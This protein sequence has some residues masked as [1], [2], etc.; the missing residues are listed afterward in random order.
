MEVRDAAG[1]FPSD[2]GFKL[3]AALE[4]WLLTREQLSFGAWC[5]FL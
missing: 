2:F 5:R 3:S 1:I 4:V